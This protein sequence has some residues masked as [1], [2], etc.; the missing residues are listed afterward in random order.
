MDKINSLTSL[1]QTEFDFLL[2]EFSYQVEM[3]ISNYTLKG[4]KRAYPKFKESR[5]SSLYGSSK[6]LEFILIYLKEH[7][8]QVFFG[9][10]FKISQAKVSEWVNFLLPILIESLRKCFLLPD[11]N[12]PFIIPSNLNSI[13]CDV[14]E[15]QINRSIDYDV[16][17][18]FYSG[19]K[20]AHTVKNLAFTDE[21][22]FIHFISNTYEGSAHDKSI[23]DDIIV[24][25]SSINILVDLGFL[26][27]DKEHENVILPY[28]TSKKVK[29]SPLQ[30]QINKGISSLRIRVE[31]AFS[32]VKRLK[33]LSQK[34]NLRS[35]EIHDY[36][37]KIGVGLH[38]LRIRF[39]TLIN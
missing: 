31:H 32:G 3:K 39:R 21:S 11:S 8:R 13:L 6:K 25:E 4:K 1:T 17:K 26:G 18:E 22:G 19:K 30:K 9:S 12:E 37:I 38:N 35:S 15:R 7:P 10:Y 14:T 5:L 34:I 24:K 29:L 27:A 20:K 16:Q 23:W 36:L 28:K 2:K 33:V